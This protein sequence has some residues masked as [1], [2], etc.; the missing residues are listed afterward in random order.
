MRDT[1][2][3]TRWQLFGGGVDTGRSEGNHGHL[4][5]SPGQEKA[6]SL[7]SSLI[8]I[9]KIINFHTPSVLEPAFTEIWLWY[10]GYRLQQKYRLF[11]E[12]YYN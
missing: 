7:S 1:S 11:P 9:P 5:Q 4:S 10:A 12:R 2:L 8:P 6:P 3:R